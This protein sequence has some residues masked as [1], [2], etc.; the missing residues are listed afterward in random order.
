M[1]REQRTTNNEQRML[2]WLT[3]SVR[4]GKDEGTNSVGNFIGWDKFS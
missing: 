2:N 3:D 1:I 4:S